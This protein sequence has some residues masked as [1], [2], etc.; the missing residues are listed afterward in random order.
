MAQFFLTVTM[1][2]GSTV[3]SQLTV[4]VIMPA[5]RLVIVVTVFGSAVAGVIFGFGKRGVAIRAGYILL[6]FQVQ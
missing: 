2:Y 3:S 1:N 4:E 5:C 6:S